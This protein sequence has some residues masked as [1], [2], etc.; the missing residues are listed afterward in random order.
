MP[1]TQENQR[2]VAPFLRV[3]DALLAATSWLGVAAT[4][5][6]LV[7][8]FSWKPELARI[9]R[10]LLAVAFTVSL[11]AAWLTFRIH[12]DRKIFRYFEQNRLTPEEFD[13]ALNALLGMPPQ[14]RSME[15]RAQGVRRLLYKLVACLACAFV[16]LLAY[17][18]L[19]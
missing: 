7:A 16:C 4:A 14:D 2:P 12:F 5:M 11:Y 9:E 18:V 1:E 15:N 13:T 17:G 3:V 10:I 19:Q 8:G 6:M